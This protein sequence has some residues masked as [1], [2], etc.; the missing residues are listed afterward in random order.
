V[1]YTRRHN[2]NAMNF[3][4]QRPRV[5]YP[6]MKK[7][8]KHMVSRKKPRVDG[9]K[10]TNNQLEEVTTYVEPEETRPDSSS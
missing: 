1:E 8:G 7:G 9:K 2:E 10:D 6:L 5:N 4:R 3:K